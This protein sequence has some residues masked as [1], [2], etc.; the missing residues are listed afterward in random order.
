MFW[1]SRNVYPGFKPRADICHFLAKDYSDSPLS[2]THADFFV[3]KEVTTQDLG[4][5]AK[6]FLNKHPA[7]SQVFLTCYLL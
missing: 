5:K 1:I 4:P 2:T 7:N 6:I 3:A